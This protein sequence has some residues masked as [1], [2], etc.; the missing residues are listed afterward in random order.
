M[1]PLWKHLAKSPLG[2]R[3]LVLKEK[4]SLQRE[5]N[6]A[7]DREHL[8]KLVYESIQKYG[9]NCDLNFID[10]SGVEDMDGIF[11]GVNRVFNG[12]V[13]QWDVSNV[14]SMRDMFHGSQFNGDISDWDVSRV[15][16]MDGMFQNSVFNGDIS[17]WN[18]SC[19]ESMSSMFEDSQFNGDIG[20]WNVS[21]VVSMWGMFAYSQ[22]NGDVS[23]WN[24]SDVWQMPELFAYS[25]FTGDVSG[26]NVADDVICVGM[27]TGSLLEMNGQIPEWYRA[28]EEKQRLERESLDI[29]EN[30]VKEEEF[31][32]S[33][34]GELENL[35]F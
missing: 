11:A 19:V 1:V 13:S 10:V 34:D 9:P 25:Q 16:Y 21:S 5:K 6:V 29:E 3:N 23:R 30:S 17:N 32:R 31:N 15:C 18:V 26:W 24:V 22:F 27:F 8:R 14:E 33:D 28:I 4:M 12:D 2:I 35:S 20:R 7:R